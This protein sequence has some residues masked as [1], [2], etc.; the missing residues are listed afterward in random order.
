MANRYPFP[1][2]PDG[3]YGIAGADDLEPGQLLPLHLLDRE[4]VLFRG[5]D[6]VARVFDAHCPHMGAHL[7]VGGTV[8]G[9]GLTCPFHG[10]RF[11]ADGHVA[12]V[13]GLA[14]APKVGTRAW[15]VRERNGR[16]FVWYH[17]LGKPP[18]YDVTP[19]RDDDTAWTPWRSDTHRVRVGVQELTENIIDRAHFLVVHDMVPPEVDRFDVQFNDYSMVVDQHVK[20]TAIVEQGVEVQT[21]TTTCGPGLVAVE[22]REGDLD[23]LTYITQ[24]P[25]DEV[26]TDITIC[27]SMRALDEEVLTNS[28]AELNAKTTNL[29]FTQDIAIW[30]NKVY[31]TK[32]ILTQV[33]GPIAQY[34]RWFSRFYSTWSPE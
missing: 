11:D 23:M 7:G 27:F 34:R 30:E 14:R 25:V 18:Q 31:L 2:V 9:E 10:W 13:P 3:W 20:V 5:D 4:L 29:Q 32:P 19:Y 21:R 1:A 22:V 24:T 8:C 12:E 33:D 26:Y 16:I 28:I 6:G 17:A 15:D